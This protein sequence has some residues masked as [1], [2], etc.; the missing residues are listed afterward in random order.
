[1]EPLVKKREIFNESFHS[2][3]GWLGGRWYD[4]KNI[5][6]EKKWRFLFEILLVLH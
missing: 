1:M 5:F 2:E 6:E 3:P 4:F